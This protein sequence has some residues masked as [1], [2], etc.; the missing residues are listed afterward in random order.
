MSELI[1]EMFDE[2]RYN[3]RARPGADS[4]QILSSQFCYLF[5]TSFSYGVFLRSPFRHAASRRR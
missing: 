1:E 5:S 2:S 3:S 4:G